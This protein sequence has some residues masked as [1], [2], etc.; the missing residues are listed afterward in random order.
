MRNENCKE[1]DFSNEKKNT[2][3]FVHSSIFYPENVLAVTK[4]LQIL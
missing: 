3:K 4:P 1:N 2:F